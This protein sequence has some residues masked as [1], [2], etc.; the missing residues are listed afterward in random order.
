MPFSDE[1]R[2]A[3]ACLP[4]CCVVR[5]TTAADMDIFDNVLSASHVQ[6]FTEHLESAPIVVMDANPPVATMQAVGEICLA[7]G[8]PL[9]FEP[10]SIPKSI[11]LLE[12]PA[13]LKATKWLS[14]NLHELS[15]M[16]EQAQAAAGT[17]GVDSPLGREVLVA[18]A[19]GLPPSL[20][21]EEGGTQS[22]LEA[23]LPPLLEAMVG[24]GGE[25]PAEA[26]RRHVFVSL[27]ASG[28]LWVDAVWLPV[29]RAPNFSVTVRTSRLH[30]Y[31]HA[32][33]AHYPTHAEIGPYL[34]SMSLRERAEYV[35]SW[36][37][38][39]LTTNCCCN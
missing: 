13:A 24:G 5:T 26:D 9:W 28:L 3:L 14:P 33:V 15:A 22:A 39:V 31:S 35:V 6:R 11:R 19:A 16:A 10:T 30:S 20:L 8:V 4:A 25:G 7:A 32:L 38:V 23:G 12:A 37:Y 17:S 1:S 36:H 29:G 27:G 21:A 18:L 34:P 2:C